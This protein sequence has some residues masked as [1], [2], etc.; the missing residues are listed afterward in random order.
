MTILTV[1]RITKTF[2]GLVAVN[3]VSFD[4]ETGSIVGLIG[5]NGAGK[6]TVFNIITGIYKPDKGDVV[7]NGQSLVVKKSHEIVKLGIARTFQTIRLFSQLS[8]LENVLAGFHCRTKSWVFGAILRLPRQQEEERQ[9]IE[10]AFKILQFVG[11][12]QYYDL[13]AGSLS[14]GNQRLLEIARALA[15]SPRLLILDEP[16][17]GMNEKET[18]ELIELIRKIRDHGITI[19]LIEH[20][21]NVV[22][23]V[24]EKVVVLEYGSKIAEG[25]PEEIRSN[26][27]VIEAYLGTG[28]NGA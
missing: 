20:D 23:D 9:K 17:G 5:P 16:A 11:I 28:D 6:T 19:L 21:M 22:M 13:P 25:T 12:E 10:E 8:V 1:Q 4:I 18:A 2:G 14:Y 26:P 3:N 15:T 24:C 27:K 7:F